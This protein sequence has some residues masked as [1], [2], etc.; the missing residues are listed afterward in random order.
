MKIKTRK[1]LFAIFAIAF[2]LSGGVLLK[3]F[4]ER[5][6]QEMVFEDISEMFPETEP[7]IKEEPATQESYVNSPSDSD[8]R[9]TECQTPSTPDAMWKARWE[10]EAK[11][12]F[13]VYHDLSRQNPDMVGWIK[14]NG[15][16]IDYPV[17]QTPDDPEYYLHKNMDGEDSSY[18]TPFLDARCTLDHQSNLMIYGHH[19]KDG[20]MFAGLQEYK[21]AAYCEQHPY[22]QF[23]TLNEAGSYKVVMAFCLDAGGTQVPWKK[24]LF[25]ADEAEFLEALEAAK[26]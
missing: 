6:K 22:I 14:I 5:R 12:R 7:I 9:Q 17:C 25:P 20:Q 26:K 16:I 21:S 15:T 4:V 18:G 3:D 8:D 10:E 11:T 1:I 19:M 13:P 23:D 2:L 24:L